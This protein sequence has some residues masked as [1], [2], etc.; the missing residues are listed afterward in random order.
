MFQDG[1]RT[2][3]EAGQ[4]SSLQEGFDTGFGYSA[5]LLFLIASLRGKVK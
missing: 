5:H 2:G 1:F 4:E 3:I